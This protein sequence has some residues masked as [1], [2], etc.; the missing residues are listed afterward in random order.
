[1][2][3]ARNRPDGNTLGAGEENQPPH[4]PAYDKPVLPKPGILA[5]VMTRMLKL[6]TKKMPR[7]PVK[8]PKRKKG[9]FY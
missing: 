9:K 4:L 5:K 8:H 6:P 7:H 3:S 2:D 1:M